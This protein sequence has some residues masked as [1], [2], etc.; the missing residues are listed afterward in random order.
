M[1]TTADDPSVGTAP[2]SDSLDELARSA[3]ES[4][5]GAIH[6]VAGGAHQAVDRV[7]QGADSALQTLRGRSE[8]WTA[9]SEESLEHVYAYVREKPLIALGMA[10]AAGFL[11]SRLMR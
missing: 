6:R 2:L 7:A 8:P 11:H 10:A 9:A 4:G 1:H 5:S 3:S